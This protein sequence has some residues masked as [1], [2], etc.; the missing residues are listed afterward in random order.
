M[1]ICGLDLFVGFEGVYWSGLGWGGG[2][3]FFGNCRWSVEFSGLIGGSNGG[4]G[5]F[6]CDDL[7]L[8][9]GIDW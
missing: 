2:L 4:Y 6:N 9:E 5:G 3:G 7:V 1:I 8:G